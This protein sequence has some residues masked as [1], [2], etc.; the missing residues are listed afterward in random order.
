MNGASSQM[1]AEIKAAI[2][3]GT[4]THSEMERR[5]EAAIAAEIEKTES[6][7][8]MFLFASVSDGNNSIDISALAGSL[9][10]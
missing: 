4:L 8:D 10:A 2:E 5:L 3:K 6:P 7:A 9:C 1:I